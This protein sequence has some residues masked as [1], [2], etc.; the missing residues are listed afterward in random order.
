MAESSV[1]M[2]PSPSQQ[3]S[4]F[5][6][7]PAEIRVNIYKLLIPEITVPNLRREDD[8]FRHREDDEFCRRILPF[9]S[10]LMLYDSRKDDQ[11]KDIWSLNQ[12]LH[13]L[14][15]CRQIYTEVKPIVDVVPIVL[16][17]PNLDFRK[18]SPSPQVL[19][20]VYKAIL[21]GRPF[22]SL[23]RIL[24]RCWDLRDQVGFLQ[25]C[26]NL[27]LAEV[28]E[29]LELCKIEY[30]NSIAKCGVT[31]YPLALLP[32]IIKWFRGETT[33]HQDKIAGFLPRFKKVTRFTPGSRVTE[34]DSFIKLHHITLIGS[35]TWMVERYDHE[36][37]EH[38]NRYDEGCNFQRRNFVLLE[39]IDSV[40]TRVALSSAPFLGA[41]R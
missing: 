7:L 26:P 39:Q 6:D 13:I 5:L 20:R 16:Y 12:G 33:S 40:S 25:E 41:I 23:F 28:K 15:V 32:Y 11:G 34:I 24:G 22:L 8:E 35:F 2:T 37:D 31:H 36:C 3:S 17:G 4:T 18:Q 1:T 29:P 21:I 10:S 30:R 27:R 38:C 19:S 9:E 14:F